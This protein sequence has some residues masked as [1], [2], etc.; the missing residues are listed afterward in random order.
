MKRSSSVLFFLTVLFLSTVA[1]ADWQSFELKTSCKTLNANVLNSSGTLLATVGCQRKNINIYDL[2]AQ[3]IKQVISFEDLQLNY[4]DELALPLIFSPDDQNVFFIAR[5][6]K[7]TSKA[8]AALV[9][10]DLQK[11]TSH[12]V[13]HFFHEWSWDFPRPEKMVT[14]RLR[15]ALDG[16]FLLVVGSTSLEETVYR[17][18]LK[19]QHF[20]VVA[21][22]YID[23]F[24]PIRPYNIPGSSSDIWLMG[25]ELVQLDALGNMQRGSTLP[26][27]LSF[28]GKKIW[29]YYDSLIYADGET[30]IYGMQGNCSSASQGFR[31]CLLKSR[32]ISKSDYK[33]DSRPDRKSVV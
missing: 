20:D 6:S 27:E 24:N 5:T 32:F 29:I 7:E 19:T 15:F 4:F 17:Y 30:F 21:R 28:N 1:V 8:T 22:G 9:H 16:R 14:G 2:K 12:I 10:V 3:K 33:P 11:N 23:Q 26:S 18:D 13:G 31:G 25:R